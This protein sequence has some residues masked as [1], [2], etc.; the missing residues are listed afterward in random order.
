ML[1]GR[2]LMKDCAGT[3]FELAS[4]VVYT[5]LPTDNTHSAP[6]ERRSCRDCDSIDIPLRW[7]GEN[8]IGFRCTYHLAGVLGGILCFD[9]DSAGNND[10]C[11]LHHG[12]GF[13]ASCLAGKICRDKNSIENITLILSGRSIDDF[14]IDNEGA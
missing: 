4:F 11:S 14:S 7:S 8:S 12:S 9:R 2:H 13:T 5:V 6:L 1:D 10:R 3:D